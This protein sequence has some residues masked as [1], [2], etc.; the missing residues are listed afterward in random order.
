MNHEE[1]HAFGFAISPDD[2]TLAV[3]LVYPN[4]TCR[5]L[6]PTCNIWVAKSLEEI[7][8]NVMRA[9]V[10]RRTRSNHAVQTSSTDAVQTRI[11]L[12]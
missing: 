1:L 12:R 8:C 9:E 2:P 11:V 4:L 10:E 7:F 6:C 3:H 5:Y